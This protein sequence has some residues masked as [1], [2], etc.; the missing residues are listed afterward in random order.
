MVKMSK[1]NVLALLVFFSN[2]SHA[3]ADDFSV[4]MVSAE[5]QEII[6][7]AVNEKNKDG[8]AVNEQIFS[9]GLKGEYFTFAPVI[10]R[11]EKAGGCYINSVTSN[12]EIGA[13][14]LISKNEGVESCDNVI[15]VFSCR[16]LTENGLGV[17]YGMRLGFDKYYSESSFFSVSDSGVL[18]KNAELSNKIGSLGSV[19]NAK[20]KLGCTK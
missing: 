6:A 11:N 2:I 7:A 4:K 13:A 1:F 9:I 14:I 20:K 8:E 5:R 3:H 16:L 18:S 10:V 17:I 12:N 19:L 15:A